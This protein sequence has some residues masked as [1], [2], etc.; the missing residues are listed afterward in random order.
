MPQDA[1]TDR[2]AT[3]VEEMSRTQTLLAENQQRMLDAQPPAEMGFAHPKYQ[4]RLR[5]EG[6]FTEFKHPV[7]Q[8]DKAC[9]AQGV[10]QATIE[11]VD[12]LREGRYI[13][14]RVEVKRGAKGSVHLHYP[15]GTPD[16][17]MR[18]NGLFRTF[19]ELIDKITAEMQ[20][21]GA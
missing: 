3:A 21:T 7:Y 14:G 10:P 12:K 20:A 13:G 11:L 2:L 18:N 6:F 16:D 8:N 17:R 9:P 1:M 4:E 5:A 19:E 15:S